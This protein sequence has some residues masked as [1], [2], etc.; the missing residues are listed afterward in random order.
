MLVEF[1]GL[2]GSGKTT[3]LKNLKQQS[4]DIIDRKSLEKVTV[5]FSSFIKFAIKNRSL[6]FIFGLGT[7]YNFELDLKRWYAL[8][9]GVHAT[10][11]Q[12]AK[13]DEV[14]KSNTKKNIIMDEGL[15]QRSLSIFYFNP[16]KL[17]LYFFKK[18]IKTILKLKIID[19]VIYLNINPITSIERCLNRTD[20]LPYR[21]KKFDISSL[22]SKFNNTIKG[23]QFIKNNCSIKFTQIN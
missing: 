3:Y 2:P 4:N 8:I 21:Y 22:K 23:I 9:I 16:R 18:T 7:L 10:L 14:N 12:F 20:G 6:F 19:E 5:S 11:K 1:I 17:N 15:L 13:I